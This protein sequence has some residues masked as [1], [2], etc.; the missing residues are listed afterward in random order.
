MKSTHTMAL[1]LAKTNS[2]VFLQLFVKK[3]EKPEF[4]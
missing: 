4:K 3:P 1:S 2:K